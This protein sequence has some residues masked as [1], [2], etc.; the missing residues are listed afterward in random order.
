ML[1][2]KGDLMMCGDGRIMFRNLN[3]VDWYTV[4]SNEMNFAHT[5]LLMLL[6]THSPFQIFARKLSSS[7]LLKRNVDA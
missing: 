7:D 1:S 2:L 6:L 3:E 5:V 4:F